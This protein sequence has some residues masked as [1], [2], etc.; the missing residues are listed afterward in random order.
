MKTTFL[1]S[2]QKMMF[3][4]YVLA[5]AG[6]LSGCKQVGPWERGNLAD[7]TMR[8]DR[9]PLDDMMSEHL[10]FSRETAT[11]GKGVGGGGCGCN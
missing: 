7:P 5:A 8:A 4:L 11:G 3:R 9:R 1:S 10:W 2:K 6:L